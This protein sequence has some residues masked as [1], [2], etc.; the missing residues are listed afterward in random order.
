MKKTDL[1]LVDIYV[2]D[3]DWPGIGGLTG[4]LIVPL[5]SVA[6]GTGEQNLASIIR[7]QGCHLHCLVLDDREDVGTLEMLTRGR[8]IVPRAGVETRDGGHAN[9]GQA[10]HSAAELDFGANLG[11]KI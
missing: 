4:C 3:L 7:R 1:Y 5:K 2:P 9:Q 11:V 8:R 10:G 6:S